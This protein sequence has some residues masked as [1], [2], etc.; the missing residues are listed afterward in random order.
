VQDCGYDLQSIFP[1][2]DRPVDTSFDVILIHRA[3]P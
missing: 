1:K 3:I 2:R